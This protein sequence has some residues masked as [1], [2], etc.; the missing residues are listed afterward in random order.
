MPIAYI[1]T[2]D[3]QKICS[4]YFPISFNLFEMDVSANIVKNN[5]YYFYNKSG[6][7]EDYEK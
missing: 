7:S 2:D 4:I 5:Y 1:K 6:P 3:E